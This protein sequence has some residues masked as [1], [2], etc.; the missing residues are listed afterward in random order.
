MPRSSWG[1]VQ[2]LGRD[3]W[4]VRWLEWRGSERHRAS[5][6]LRCTKREADAFLARMRV[7]HE[8]RN[9]GASCPTFRECWDGWYLPEL[10]RR[11]ADG[12]L[13][14]NTYKL[15]DVQW[16]HRVLHRWGDA[17]MS[18]VKAS[19]YQAWLLTLSHVDA[20][21]ANVLVGNMV[22]CCIRHDVRGIDFKSVSYRLP[23]DTRRPDPSDVYT[24]EE[25]SAICRGLIDAGSVCAVPAVLMAFGSARVGE[26][27]APLS[28]DVSE[29]EVK[30]ERMAVVR[31][32]KQ[33]QEHGREATGLKTSESE[34]PIVIWGEWASFIL[35]RAGSGEEHLNGNGVGGPV[36]RMTVADH[37]R[38]FFREGSTDVRYLPMMKLRNSWETFMRWGLGI[39]KDKIDKMMGHTSSDVRSKHYDRPDE[40][41]FAETVADAL[42][43]NK[44]GTL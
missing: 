40:I 43:R 39:D 9:S 23:R 35:E 17:V 20:R 32:D 30:G 18:E 11:M 21:H 8:F 41:M 5:K 7:E 3:R 44:L 16:R 33:L 31:I 42:S 2:K 19:D 14:W 22:N 36:R 6:V 38:R 34:R 4:R 25:Y 10:Q 12:S 26:A 13:A 15:Y 29:V 37:W 1:T 28:S 27:C 24:L